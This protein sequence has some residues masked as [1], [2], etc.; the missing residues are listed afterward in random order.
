MRAQL[1]KVLLWSREHPKIAG[2][3]GAAATA[4]AAF[5]GGP[6]AGAAAAKILP[7]ICNSLSLC[8]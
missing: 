8:A 5:Y 1:E 2:T 6:A 4:A 7:V 3:I